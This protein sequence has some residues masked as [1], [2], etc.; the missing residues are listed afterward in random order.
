[1]ARVANKTAP[2]AKKVP[3]ADAGVAKRALRKA[4][5]SAEVKV[6]SLVGTIEKQIEA[7][8]KREAAAKAK[9]RDVRD[10]AAKSGTKAA[11]AAVIKARAAVREAV[12]QGSA[13]K[14][15]LRKAK[16]EQRVQET[17]AKAVAAEQRAAAKIAEMEK[18]LEARARKDLSAAVARFEAGWLKAR[19]ALDVKK[20]K[21]IAKKE[22]EQARK[23]KKSL[24]SKVKAMIK[25]STSTR[26]PKA[27]KA[28]ASAKPVVKR[29][30]PPKAAAED[31][32]EA[33]KRRGRPPK[34]KAAAAP[35]TP[36]A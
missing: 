22:V 16:V 8:A 24:E 3:K 7:A 19:K 15:E 14:Q 34:A 4:T 10:R 28:D 21:S 17:L 29:G 20:L 1:M 18:K 12:A 36:E 31:T 13:L 9:L 23:V 2:K 30:R 11:K 27:T 5:A 32:A 6:K 25:E 35:A 26:R 33:P